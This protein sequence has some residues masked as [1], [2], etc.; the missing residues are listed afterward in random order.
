M[1]EINE[2]NGMTTWH[3]LNLVFWFTQWV[4]LQCQN[5]SSTIISRF[6]TLPRRKALQKPSWRV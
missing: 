5:S 6:E 4:A 3:S 1:K 2:E